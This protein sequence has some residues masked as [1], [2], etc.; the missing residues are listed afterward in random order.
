M[1]APV[2]MSAV[3]EG[4]CPARQPCESTAEGPGERHLGVASVGDGC[5]APCS[6]L[7]RT[8]HPRGGT[9]NSGPAW[10]G[11]R[12]RPAGRGR[13]SHTHAYTHICTHIHVHTRTHCSHV[14]TDTCTSTHTCMHTY[15]RTQTHAHKHICAV[16]SMRRTRAYIHTHTCTCAGMHMP[17]RTSFVEMPASMENVIMGKQLI[18]GSPGHSGTRCPSWASQASR[19]S[20][21]GR[22][23]C[24]ACLTGHHQT[25]KDSGRGCASWVKPRQQHSL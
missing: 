22:P 21:R 6:P 20:C 1:P 24:P 19:R 25:R 9:P 14:Y 16:Q 10:G 18:C 17:T 15:I 7:P 23:A 13:E 4:G 12:A 11:T 5:G 2:L 8:A 3:G